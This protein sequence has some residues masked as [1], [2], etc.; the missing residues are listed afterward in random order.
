[1]AMAMAFRGVVTVSG[2]LGQSF[3]DGLIWWRSLAEIFAEGFFDS[4]SL[5]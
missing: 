1:M 5:F 4:K 3:L 2:G